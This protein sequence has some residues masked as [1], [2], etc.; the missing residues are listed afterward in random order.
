V[1]AAL[2]PGDDVLV[3]RPTY[4]PFLAVPRLFGANPHNPSGVALSHEEVLALAAVSEEMGAMVL[5][6][7][8]YLEF[9]EGE[10]AGTAF[11]LAVPFLSADVTQMGLDKVQTLR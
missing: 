1:A 10:K 11:G 4:E 5:I 8:I 7:E 6:D 3:E 9:L 2:G